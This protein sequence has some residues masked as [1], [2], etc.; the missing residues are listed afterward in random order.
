MTRRTHIEKD[1]GTAEVSLAPQC[2]KSCLPMLG[3][4]VEGGELTVVES[5]RRDLVGASAA[6]MFWLVV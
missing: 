3:R 4:A 2:P 6:L 5:F 1:Q